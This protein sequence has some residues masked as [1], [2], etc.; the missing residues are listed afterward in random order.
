MVE[1]CEMGSKVSNEVPGTRDLSQGPAPELIPVIVRV[2]GASVPASASLPQGTMLIGSSPDAQL[3]LSDPTVSRRHAAVELLPGALRVKDLGSRNGTFYLGARISE[4]LVPLGGSVRVG[5]TTVRFMPVETVP[6]VS[7]KEVL[8]GLVGRSQPMRRLFAAIEKLGPKDIGVLVTGET[9]TGKEGVARALHALSAR[10]QQPLTVFDCAAVSVS[11]AESELFGYVKGAF[12]GADRARA[13]V[14]ERAGEGTLFLDEIGDLPLEL[15][16]KLLRALDSRRFQ[17]VGDSQVREFRARVVAATHR[18]LEAEVRDG[19]FRKDLFFRI[20]PASLHVPPLRERPEDV[21]LL[22]AQLAL[23]CA[24]FEVP[25]APATLAAL[26]CDPWPGNVRELK[27]AVERMIAL[28]Y[29]RL[30]SGPNGAPPSFLKARNDMVE[31]FERDYLAALLKRHP[32]NVGAAI[33]ESKLSKS[34]FYRLLRRHQ[35]GFIG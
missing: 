20:A 35:V 8:C 26:M 3:R 33:R 18:D 11:L 25:L 23:E 21:P 15:Q 31:R 13:G 24:G 14:L 22:A 17:R 6:A 29:H 10:R 34:E 5:K 16:P 30:E 19:R 28:G 9:G 2:E 27:N 4:A 7:D 1:A 32:K 12:T